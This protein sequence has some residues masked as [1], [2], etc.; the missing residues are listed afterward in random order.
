VTEESTKEQIKRARRLGDAAVQTALR[1]QLVQARLERQLRYET[2]GEAMLAELC[3]LDLPTLAEHVLVHSLAGLVQ[4]GDTHPNA[5]HRVIA[6]REAGA[7]ALRVQEVSAEL[8]AKHP[9]S[10]QMA[11]NTEGYVLSRDEAIE[12]LR[13]RRKLVQAQMR[14]SA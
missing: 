3:R 8:A 2:R 10:Q 14:E 11:A 9:Q 1:D 12:V 4:I 6:Y 13:T 7:L 5:K